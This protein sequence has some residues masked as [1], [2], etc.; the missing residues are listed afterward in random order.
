MEVAQVSKQPWFGLAKKAPFTE[1]GQRA[2]KCLASIGALCFL[3]RVHPVFLDR[4]SGPQ[5][6]IPREL[7]QEIL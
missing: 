3:Q 5:G 2:G 4:H 7:N 6:V 1:S